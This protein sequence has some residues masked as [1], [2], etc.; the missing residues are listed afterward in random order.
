MKLLWKPLVVSIL[1]VLGWVGYRLLLGSLDSLKADEAIMAGAIVP[2][3]GIGYVIF[4]GLVASTVWGEWKGI[5]AAID[6]KDEEAFIRLKDQ[7]LS[8]HVKLL[9]GVFSGL[10]L[11]PIFS[12]LPYKAIATGGFANFAITFILLIY[13]E[14][15]ND[16]DD[17][18]SGV[19]NIDITKLPEVWRE[20]YFNH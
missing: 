9:V 19:W 1:V 2:I 12:L 6:A 17:Y 8:P 15:I 10:L 16:L 13:W 20:K 3:I 18:F 4:A 11:F 5:V 14:V 7:R